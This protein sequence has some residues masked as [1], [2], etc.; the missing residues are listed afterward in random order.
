MSQFHGRAD[1]R[2]AVVCPHEVAAL[3]AGIACP[4][5][6]AG[7]WALDLFLGDQTRAHE[8]LDVGILRRDVIDVLTYLSGWEVFEAQSQMLYRL[9]GC[10]HPRLNVNSL[11]CRPAH[12]QCWSF[13]LMLDEAQGKDWVFR[14]R[15]TVRMPLANVI[16]RTQEGIPYLT[17]EIQLL[18]KA[19]HPRAKDRDDFVRVLPRLA[20]D[21]RTWLSE[22]LSAIDPEHA[23]LAKLT[24]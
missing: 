2:W 22:A 20:S 3:L 18:Y 19:R 4:W 5:W 14:R 11:W 10:E 16:K 9:E 8:D 12:A 23:W 24:I 13:E 21:E 1:G 7:G 17:P 6:I 15:P